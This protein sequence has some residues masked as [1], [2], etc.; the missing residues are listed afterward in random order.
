MDQLK[1]GV[2]GVGSR[3]SPD[4]CS[5]LIVHRVAVP[6]DAFTVALHDSLLE[7]GREISQILGVGNNDFTF[8][9]PKIIVPDT[10]KGKYYGDVFLKRSFSEMQI[11]LSRSLQKSF[12]VFR[13]YSQTNTQ[14]YGAP[15]GKA[16]PYPIVHREGVFWSNTKSGSFFSIG[17][18]RYKMFAYSCFWSIF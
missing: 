2:L 5:C 17:R 14:P 15:Q 1:E 10:E 8:R 12:K 11:H 9:P 6:T 16:S 3:S 4:D 7:I 18:D 13:A